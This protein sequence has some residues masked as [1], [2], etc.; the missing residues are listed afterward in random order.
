MH[1]AGVAV[2]V[3]VATTGIAIVAGAV[4]ALSR[5]GWWAVPSS[6]G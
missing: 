1:N 3:M 6:V 2:G 5:L 4:A